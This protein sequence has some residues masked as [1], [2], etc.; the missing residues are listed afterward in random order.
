MK[1]PAISQG[2]FEKVATGWYGGVNSVENPWLL[3]DNQSRW[4]VN[5]VNRGGIWQSRPGMY[6]RLT[7]PRGN[8]QGIKFFK[9]TREDA[10][11]GT[12][13]MF[14][15][16]GFI[17]Y[18]PFP[19]T[20]VSDWTPFRLQGIQFSS[21]APRIYWAVAE[22][23]TSQ[24]ADGEIT[25]IPTYSV[26]MMQDGITPAAYFDGI[27]G[28]HLNENAPALQT[29]IGTWM[30]Y[31][32]GR[33]WVARGK[34]VIAGD[35]L[36][37]LSFEERVNSATR[38]DFKFVGDVTALANSIADNRQ[39]NLV[40]FT[41]ENAETLLSSIVTRA[42]WATTQNFQTLLFPST[43]C[44]AGRS[45][46]NHA[47]LLWWYSSSGLV[48]SDSA[49]AAFLTS[50]IRYRDIEMAQSK[51]NFASDLSGICAASFESYLLMAVPSGDTFNAH[52]M[53]LDYS[54][55]D[56]LNR[57]APPAWNGVWKGPRPVEWSSA[58]IS[59]ERKLF[60]GSV[61]YATIQGQDS[62][63]H[64]W[65]AFQPNRYDSYEYFDSANTRISVPVRIY[66]EVET[67]LM[68][69]GMDLKRFNF[70]EA[71]LVEIG[72]D[73]DLKVS[74]GGTKGA[75]HE[76]LTKRINATL[77]AGDIQNDELQTLAARE[78]IFKTQSRR[79]SSQPN[80]DVGF[81]IESVESKYTDNID[82]AFGLRFQWCGQMGIESVR[83]YTDPEPEPAYGA[84]EADDDRINVVTQ[85]GRAFHFP[86][87][88]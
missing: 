12:M 46:I 14:A 25:I 5:C 31:S 83:I 20:Q 63:N 87:P 56:Q 9:A 55:A 3:Q 21:L 19:L 51:R 41:E 84:C 36:N 37:P 67:K 23:S 44:I 22:K 54:V 33:L 74:Y 76:V 6:C 60:C 88:T 45:V 34:S 81:D 28:G 10:P 4:A 75:Y 29:P 50:Q 2:R 43:G 70:L 42:T 86:L 47:G 73:V 71:D 26:L 11:F 69:D 15:V 17:Y 66:S 79:V 85:D 59:G 68:G 49:A 53:V 62:V 30:A 48:N 72:G 65:E 61:D 13:M 27:N 78:G 52:T 64:I 1:T 24:A 57:D 18:A 82:K 80:T 8:F 58:V 77:V 7:I 35:A 39:S 40:V 32:G 38:G 16:D